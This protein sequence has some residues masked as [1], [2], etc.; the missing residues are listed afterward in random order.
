MDKKRTIP[1]HKVFVGVGCL[2]V[3][4]AVAGYLLFNQPMIG[5]VALLIG[6]T[7][8]NFALG[9]DPNRSIWH[10]LR[11]PAIILVALVWVG[12]AT[13]GRHT[14]TGQITKVTRVEERHSDY[15]Y[16]VSF[17]ADKQTYQLEDSINIL[18]GKS[19]YLHLHASAKRVTVTT[20]GVLPSNFLITQNILSVKK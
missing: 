1:W 20:S 15:H 7:L 5:L 6:A 2:F 16:A 4:F 19:H 10:K 14:Y 3:V 11:W 17:K 18:A 12:L 9:P 8:L 13:L